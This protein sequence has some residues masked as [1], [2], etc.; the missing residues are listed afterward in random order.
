MMVPITQYTGMNISQW[1]FA[2]CTAQA[3][4]RLY[5]N[6]LGELLGEPDE[7]TFGSADVAEPIRVFVLHHVADEL[8]AARAEPGECLVDVVYGEHNA[9]VAERVHRRVPVVGDGRR[10]EKSRE[11]EPAVAI[12]R[13]HHGDLDVL[14]AQSGDAR[15][16]LS[17]DRRAPFELHAKPG[18]NSNR[19][20]EGCDDVA[21]VVHARNRHISSSH[22]W[23]ETSSMYHSKKVYNAYTRRTALGC[24]QSPAPLGDDLDCAVD[25]F[26]GGL[27]VNRITRHR[28]AGGPSFC[29]S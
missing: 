13:D 3:L 27:V 20:I 15:S 11:L 4:L 21:A 26:D 22:A 16:P 23:P 18:E 25:H 28:H 5:G 19:G 17:F 9:Q 6:A 12:G 14:L 2:Y 7:Q 29:I 24:K 8:R 10:G 1:S